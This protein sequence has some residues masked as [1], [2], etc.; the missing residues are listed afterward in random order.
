MRMQ[1]KYVKL[2]NGLDVVIRS[3]IPKEAKQYLQYLLKVYGESSYVGLTSEEVG[4]ITVKK[5]KK[6][7]AEYEKQ[8]RNILLA[9]FG[10]DVK[11]I[12]DCKLT[13]ISENDRENH[14]ANVLISVYKKL[15]NNGAGSALMNTALD[16]AAKNGFKQFEAD[17]MTDNYHALFLLEKFGFKAVGL[18]PRCR[19][20][21]KGGY[22]DYLRIIKFM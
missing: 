18:L 9:A 15:W 4:S 19:K 1:G 17:I 3:L 6:Q 14:R 5:I 20:D 22:Y 12:A 10:R 16:Y 21:N 8:G 7:I 2:N 13:L 11:I